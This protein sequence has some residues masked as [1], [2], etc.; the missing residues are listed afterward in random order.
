MSESINQSPRSPADVS[1]KLQMMDFN[2]HEIIIADL[3]SFMLS[4]DQLKSC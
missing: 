2:I 3:T 1:K 4:S